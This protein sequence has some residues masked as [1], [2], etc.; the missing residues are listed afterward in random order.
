MERGVPTANQGKQTQDQTGR[1]TFVEDCSADEFSSL[2]HSVCYRPFFGPYV[3]S[4]DR[5][6]GVNER[7]CG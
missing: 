4:R 1:T 7:V 6:T 2:S 5:Q 3:L